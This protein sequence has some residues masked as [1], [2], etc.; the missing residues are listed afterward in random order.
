MRFKRVNNDMEK[1]PVWQQALSAFGMSAAVAVQ[2]VSMA[3]S[4]YTVCGKAV[5]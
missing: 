5:L 4:A 2:M 3:A 1:S